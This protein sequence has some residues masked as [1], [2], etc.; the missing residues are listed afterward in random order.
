M[1]FASKEDNIASLGQ[2]HRCLYGLVAVGDFEVLVASLNT[3][4]HLAQ[5]LR[6]VFGAR[7][8]R[9][10][11]CDI[12]HLRRHTTH[13]GAF[14]L[15]SVATA[16]A[17]HN[18]AL[19]LAADI[20]NRAN[21]IFKRVGRMREVHNRHRAVFRQD[22]LKATADRAKQAQMRQHLLLRKA[23]QTRCAIDR[24][25]V[26]GVK[27]A[28]EAHPH[29]AVVNAQLHTLVQNLYNLGAEVGH[30]TQREC[31]SLG[32][33]VLQHNLAISIVN[34]YQRKGL[35]CQA[36]KEEF[37]GTDILGKGLVVVKVFVGDIRKE[38]A[39][40]LD[41]ADTLLHYRVR[42][43]LHK[44]VFATLL[45]HLAHHRIEANGIGRG[46]G[47]LNLPRAHLIHYGRDKSRLVA[48]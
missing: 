32:G 42:R 39:N 47:G 23:Q 18:Q 21:R 11:D 6:R 5:N 44:A 45:Y 31:I 10:K 37:L 14:C 48:H 43:T 16:T 25:E 34:I 7:V 41:T 1:S 13:N 28:Q 24:Q 20:L 38:R 22:G 8:V 2:H 15:I 33:G 26:V 35:L 3:R 19:P 30:L 29:I 36:V 40:E 9:C 27:F 4:L 17:H 12:G 46:V